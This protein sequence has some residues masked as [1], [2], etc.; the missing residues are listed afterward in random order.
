MLMLMWPSGFLLVFNILLK[1]EFVFLF[2][3]TGSNTIIQS[4]ELLN[5]VKTKFLGPSWDSLSLTLA[6]DVSTGNLRVYGQSNFASNVFI[7]VSDVRVLLGSTAAKGT[8]LKLV[9]ILR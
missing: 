3:R 1:N 9:S 6:A 2:V 8:A 4:Q 7:K 5:E